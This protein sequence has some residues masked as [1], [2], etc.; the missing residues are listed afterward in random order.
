MPEGHAGGGVIGQRIGLGCMRLSTAPDRD[1]ANGIRV[2]HAAL[3]S[4]VTHLD[5][6]DVYCFDDDDIGHNERLIAEALRT[7]SGDR[8]RIEVATK[9]GLRR[10]KGAWVPDGRAA[11]L[12]AACA[13]SQT[14]LGADVIDLYYLHVVDVRVPLQTSVRA[15]AALQRD[16]LIRHVGLSNVTA[17]QIEAAR[18]IVEIDAVQVPLSV[19]DNEFL[20]NGVAEYCA[21][22]GI[23]LVAYRP[24]GGRQQAG[25]LARADSLRRIAQEQHATAPEIALAWLLDLH[26]CITPIPGPTQPAH[27][28]DLMRSARIELTAEQR[29]ELDAR[30][31]GRLLRVPRAQRRAPDDAAG[32]VVIIM[33]M[34]GAGKS[35]LAQELAGHGY[36]RLNRDAQGGRLRDLVPA[37]DE[38]LAQGKREWVLD[39]TYASRADRSDVLECAWRHGV[40]VRVIWLDT[41]IADAQINAITRLIATH[42]SLPMPEDIRARGKSDHRYFGPDAQ[43]R[44]LRAVEPPHASEGFRSIERRTFQRR[45]VATIGRRAVFFDPAEVDASGI[46]ALRTYQRE[47]WLLIGLAWSPPG[48]KQ[49]RPRDIEYEYVECTHPAG[50]PVCWCRKPLP[51]LVLECAARWHLDLHA[52]ILAGSAAADQTMALRLGMQHLRGFD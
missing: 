16:G 21:E 35:T 2:I 4:G 14:A 34:P 40:P 27:A 6:A 32:D 9:G 45:A 29:A 18:A 50:P 47:G 28:H 13:A 49:S 8:A 25:R 51:G 11:H 24:L 20:R 38:G 3:D 23:R 36:T 12:K 33:G 46:E 42:G 52:C 44:Y 10:P 22:H 41:D 37:L 7:W 19:I 48:R 30:F 5:T 26:P 1:P 43:F 31:N 15:L 39:N 17:S